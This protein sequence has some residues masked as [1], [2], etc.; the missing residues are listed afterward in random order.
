MTIIDQQPSR[1]AAPADRFGD[2]AAVSALV[3]LVLGA[4]LTVRF[5]TAPLEDAAML[6]R[7][8]EHLAAGHGLVWNIG[9]S[10]V[11]GAT[12]FLFTIL[13]AAVVHGGVPVELAARLVAIVGW[14]VTISVVFHTARRAHGASAFV[15]FLAAAVV[16]VGTATLYISAGFGTTF[17]GMWVAILLALAFRLRGRTCRLSS[18]L[19]FGVVWL[20]L[21]LTRPE[22]VLLG[23]FV[24]APLA[25]DAGLARS[26]PMVLSA[27][28]VLAV[29]GG[30]YFGWRWSYF[31]HPLPNPFYKKGAAVLHIDGLLNALRSLMMFFVPFVAIWAAALCRPESRRTT[32]FTLAP[33]VLFTGCWILLSPEMNYAARFQYACAVMIAQSWPALLPASGR[34]RDLG[35]GRWP[36]RGATGILVAVAGV[37]AMIAP[38]VFYQQRAG[39]DAFD[40]RAGIGDALAPFASRG[41]LLATTEAGLLPL[42]S[43]WRSLDTWGL[44]DQVIAHRGRL[45]DDD[46]DRAAPAVLFT[47][48]PQAPGRPPVTDPVLGQRW[49]DMTVTIAEWAENRNYLLVRSAGKSGASTWNIWVRPNTPD[50]ERLTA[51]LACSYPNLADATPVAASAVLARERC[52]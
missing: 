27:C 43:G 49:T 6:M 48:A 13:V 34:L 11:D 15:A 36:L 8:A 12:D 45:T 50:T 1:S 24:L 47:H 14:L 44:N 46:L 22:G 29:L 18:G 52:P 4:L 41:Y 30:A 10:P 28:G 42:R 37:V 26:R 5:N 32:L 16:I 40:E 25:V 7:Y 38:T 19:A 17:F 21:G 39:S 20:L 23:F 9:D 2:R 35:G 51:L 3:M 31:G 33:L